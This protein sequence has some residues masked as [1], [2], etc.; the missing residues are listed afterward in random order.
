MPCSGVDGWWAMPEPT[1]TVSRAPRWAG[2][3][4]GSA[5]IDHVLPLVVTAVFLLPLVWTVSA[6]LRQPG[7]PPPR[8]VEWIPSSI[9]LDNYA[10]MM[11]LVPMGRYLLNSLIV[12]AAAV[13]LTLLV[14]S[15][16]GFAMSQLERRSRR[17]LVVLSIGV[18]MV[19]V[20]ALWLT[21]FLLLRAVGL[22]DSL[23]ALMV[24]ALMGSSPLFVLLFFWTFRRVPSELFESAR[25]E[26]AGPVSVW[27][28][29]AMPLAVPTTVAVSVLTFLLYWSDFIGPLLYLKS[30]D[31]YTLP[32]G[33]RHLQQLDRSDWPLLMAA[34]VLLAVPALAMF[35]VAQRFFISDD[36]LSEVGGT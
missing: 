23:A 6:S 2:T 5:V 31:L 11:E 13:P 4:H 29:V 20:T 33:V 12:V 15:L 36:R 14:A 1:A 19:P 7:L 10:R 26:G 22:V 35:S 8:T 21:R 17:A 3:P 30:P 27:R 18:L 32:V 34:S 16:A 9:A 28:R 25:L 24:P